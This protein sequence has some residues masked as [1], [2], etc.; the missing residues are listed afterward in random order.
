[1]LR[2]IIGAEKACSVTVMEQIWKFRHEQFVERLGWEDIRR[3]DGR[4]I[5]E[6]DTG[7]AIHLPLIDGDEVVGYTRLLP[8]TEPHLLSHVYPELMDGREWP[9]GATIYEWTRCIAAEWA[10]PMEDVP[11]SSVL[12]T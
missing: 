1:M 6:F 8:T 11:A 10:Q 5:D 2:A 7:G 9:R 12:M 3:A 4:E